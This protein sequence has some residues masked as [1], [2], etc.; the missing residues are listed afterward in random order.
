MPPNRVANIRRKWRYVDNSLKRAMKHLSDILTTVEEQHLGVGLKIL[1]QMLHIDA[2]RAAN[3]E[4]YRKH[5]AGTE[6]GLWKD[7]DFDIIVSEGKKI[8]DP[9]GRS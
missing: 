7:E 6:R 1:N 8:P 2:L 9:S 4:L 3:L 5:W